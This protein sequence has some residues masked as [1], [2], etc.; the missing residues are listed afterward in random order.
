MKNSVVIIMKN[1]RVG[2]NLINNLKL[3]AA[4]FKAVVLTWWVGT[5]KWVAEPFSVDCETFP[6]II[7]EIFCQLQKYENTTWAWWSCGFDHYFSFIGLFR[8]LHQQ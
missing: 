5:Q 3:V 1:T 6:E 4:L 2:S 8:Y 7:F